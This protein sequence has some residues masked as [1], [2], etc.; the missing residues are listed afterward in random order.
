MNISST[1]IGKITSVVIPKTRAA[2][3][4]ELDGSGAAD[5]LD[6]SGRAKEV[7]AGLRALKAAPEVRQDKVDS[8]AERLRE[9]KLGISADDIAS[10]IIGSAGGE[11]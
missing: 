1:S 3:A 6:I 11:E 8:V 5:R 10:R 7:A 2:D 9:G 4:P